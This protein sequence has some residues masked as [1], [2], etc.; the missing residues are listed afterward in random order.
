VLKEA[1]RDRL[2]KALQVLGLD[3]QKLLT[4][5]STSWCDREGRHVISETDPSS[6]EL[7]LRVRELHVSE[8]SMLEEVGLWRHS[9]CPRRK[10]QKKAHYWRVHITVLIRQV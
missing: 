6:R 10:E 8:I 9:A 5:D 2:F 7:Q 4:N 1:S 3:R